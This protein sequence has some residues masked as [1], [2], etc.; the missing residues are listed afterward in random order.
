MTAF[1]NQMGSLQE[2]VWNWKMRN[3]AFSIHRLNLR[4]G[5]F[6]WIF[7]L[8]ANHSATWYS[9]NP[10]TSLTNNWNQADRLQGPR[11]TCDPPHHPYKPAI[12]FGRHN[13]FEWVCE[14]HITPVLKGSLRVVIGL[15]W[16]N[17]AG[18]GWINRYRDSAICQPN[19]HYM[20]VRFGCRNLMDWLLCEYVLC[21]RT[22]SFYDLHTVA[23]AIKLTIRI[24]ESD[25]ES[26]TRLIMC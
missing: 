1:G 19:T 26:T 23:C 10:T 21:E 17:I 8:I 25:L 6:P 11:V 15:R 5:F 3:C 20:H 4:D 24:T 7:I 13:Y 16:R 12:L 18:H 14:C 9:Q 2:G 22:R